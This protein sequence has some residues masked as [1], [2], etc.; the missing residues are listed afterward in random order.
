MGSFVEINDTLRISKE[1]GFPSGLEIQ[2]HLN[3]QVDTSDYV[4]KVF[5]FKNK[6]KI[7][8]YQQPPIRNFLVEY[9]DGKWLY[10]GHCHILEIV[11]DYENEVTRGKYKIVRINSVEEMKLAF[12]LIH[13]TNPHENYFQ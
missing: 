9:L 1:Q 12:E 5:E 3:K 7:R 11:H 6:E 13:L 2:D 8:V 10:W 4:G